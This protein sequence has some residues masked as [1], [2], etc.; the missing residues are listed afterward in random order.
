MERT[1]LMWD[2]PK[3]LAEGGGIK[4]GAI[5]RDPAQDQLALI[6]GLLQTPKKGDD[7]VMTRIVIE[8]LIRNPFELP[9]IDC[10]EHTVRPFVKFIDRDI[11]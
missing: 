10:R 9:V 11:A 5:C 8:H 2:V 3:H 1:N 4:R 7:I 6:Q